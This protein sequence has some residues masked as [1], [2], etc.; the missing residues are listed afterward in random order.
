MSSIVEMTLVAQLEQ[1]GILFDR[2][3][4][5]TAP[6]WFRADFWVSPDILV[7]VEGGTWI[8]GRHVRGKGFEDGCEKQAL[9]VIAGFRY[10]RCTT[11]QVEDGTCLSWIEQVRARG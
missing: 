7:E 11:E 6:R 9:A 2:E 3:V 1:A 5:F 4:R 8:A 10:L